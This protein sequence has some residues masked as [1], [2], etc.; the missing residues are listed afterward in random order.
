MNHKFK[1]IIL[2]LGDISILYSALYLTLLLRYLHP[3]SIETWQTHF[4]PFSLTFIAWL[5]IFYISDLYN[6]YLAINDS[7]FFNRTI[8]AGFIAALLSIAFFYANPNIKISPKTNLLIYVFVFTFL[9]ILWR[10]FF[11]WSLKS[12]LP[13]NKIAFI[14]KNNLVN[15]LIN[16]LRKNPQLGIKVALLAGNYENQM[17]GIKIIK[18]INN[19]DKIIKEKNINEIVLASN[20]QESD[21]LRSAL[22]KCLPLKINFINASDFYESITGKVSLESLN[23]MWFLEKLNKGKR[24][25]QDLFK[26]FYDFVMALI[27]LIISASFW[28]FIALL[29]KAESKGPVFI[30]M[31]RAGQNGAPFKMLKFRT[32]REEGN[33]RTPT[34]K[35][36]PRITKFGGFMRKTRI[37]EIPQIINILLNNMSFVGPR[38]ERP[39]LIQDLEKLIPF[40]NERTLVKPGVTGWDQVSGEYHSPSLEDSLKKLQYD[41]FYVKNRSLY[42]DLSIILKTIKTVLGKRGI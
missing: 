32:M 14:G 39:E 31:E 30:K 33:T 4:W 8:R 28:P 20:P 36:D 15:E 2:I 41:L 10:R 37:D 9:F 7:D 17:D 3:V 19:L 12:Y 13:K 22:F 21:K 16:T 11:N 38:P 34:I 6:L 29:I 18:D 23:Q 25:W 42:L 24:E 27:L 40:Y 1:K 26:R 35:N 5:I